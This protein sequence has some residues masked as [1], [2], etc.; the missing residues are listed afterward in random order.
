M[1]LDVPISMTALMIMIVVDNFHILKVT[2]LK[3]IL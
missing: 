2:C 1:D 3:M